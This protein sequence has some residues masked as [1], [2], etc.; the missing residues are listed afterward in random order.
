MLLGGET[1]MKRE[2]QVV[3]QL[4]GLAHVRSLHEDD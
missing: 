3:H 2:L 1:E 4:A